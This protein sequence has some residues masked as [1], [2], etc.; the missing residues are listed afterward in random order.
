M[1]RS[2][3]DDGT[4]L[5][6]KEA[7]EPADTLLREMSSIS[8]DLRDFKEGIHSAISELKGDIRKD[9]KDELLTLKQE[10]NQ[11]LAEV[12]T[13]L[14]AQGQAITAA[15]ERISD[16]ETSSAVTKEALLNILKEQR[17]LR[18]KLT[19]LESRSRRN[20]IRVYGVPEDSENGSVIQFM[21]KLLTTELTLP[22][23]MSLQIQRAHRA[24]T[25][26]PGPDAAP[27][28][29]VVNF[30]QF[31]VK[32]TVLKLAWKKKVFINTKQIFFD[33]DYAQ[34]VMEK[35]RAYAGAKKALKEKGIRFQTPFTRI[36]IHWNTGPRTY[37]DAQ[38][39]T[40]ELKARGFQVTAMREDPGPSM[41]ENILK[42]FPWQRADARD[43]GDQMET[44]VKERLQEF[45]RSPQH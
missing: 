45:R 7:N 5:A 9:L 29:I 44:R 36:Q 43:G 1:E 40:R 27:R 28:S 37:E 39:A 32:E 19:D 22:D 16:V 14:Q 38:Q 24:L 15:E 4:L 25:Q 34:E 30:L 18:E 6:S 26:K 13:T 12:G 23:G 42:A 10:L 17:R 2:D 33:H 11:K 20:N 8:K 41:E 31:D 3:D 35:R 21:E